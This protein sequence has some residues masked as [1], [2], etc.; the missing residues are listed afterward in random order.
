MASFISYIHHNCIRLGIHWILRVYTCVCLSVCPCVR[1]CVCVH[2]F[3]MCAFFCDKCMCFASCIVCP[4]IHCISM[5]KSSLPSLVSV[6]SNFSRAW[7]ACTCI[8]HVHTAAQFDLVTQ[9]KQANRLEP[10][11]T[12]F[13]LH[14]TSVAFALHCIAQHCTVRERR[15]NIALPFILLLLKSK[16]PESSL[17]GGH[18]EALTVAAIPVFLYAIFH[19]L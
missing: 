7:N 13:V 3:V 4:I 12:L 19:I 6:V 16:Q 1:P 9:R 8:Y 10:P 15:S 14:N 18:S 2:V 5:L 17:L 11:P